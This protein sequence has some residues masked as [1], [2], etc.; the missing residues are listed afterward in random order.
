M[1]LIPIETS[2]GQLNG[3]DA[4][5]LDDISFDYSKHKVTFKGE[6]N[7]SLCS[8]YLGNKDFILYELIFQN[9]YDFKMTELDNYIEGDN[10][11]TKSSFGF[12]EDSPL[13][14][15]IIKK[16]GKRLPMDSKHFILQTYDDVFDI[17]ATDFELKINATY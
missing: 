4:I 6:F 15:G 9:V 14:K 3:R 1:T 11:E 2:I 8:N 16:V 12:V 10:I 13:I 17:V 7:C 5:F